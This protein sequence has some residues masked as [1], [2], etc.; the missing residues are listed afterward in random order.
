MFCKSKLLTHRSTAFAKIT[1]RGASLRLAVANA[2][3]VFVRLC[4]IQPSMRCETALANVSKKGG[5]DQP[6]FA[7]D[8]EVLARSCTPKSQIPCAVAVDSVANRRASD[9]HASEIAL[10]VFAMSTGLKF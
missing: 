2:H 10:A 6:I 5:S 1:N 4:S 7:N 8:H 3:A 9:Q